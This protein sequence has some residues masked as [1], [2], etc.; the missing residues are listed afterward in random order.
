MQQPPA[1]DPF[2]RPAL[3]VL[4]ALGFGAAF[5]WPIFAFTQPSK[6]FHF[7]YGAWLL[8]L[9]ALFLVSRGNRSAAGVGEGHESLPAPSA[10]GAKDQAVS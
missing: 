8:S 3:H 10:D 1:N 5:L 2:A 6:T 7:S 4:L 9:V